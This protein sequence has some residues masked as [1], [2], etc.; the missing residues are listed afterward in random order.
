LS[1][2]KWKEGHNSY[3]QYE[4][5]QTVV[6][7][8]VNTDTY[9]LCHWMTIMMTG[10]AKCGLKL[11]DWTPVASIYLSVVHE[12]RHLEIGYNWTCVFVFNQF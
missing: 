11:D 2:S 5:H 7:L 12:C 10:F 3:I 1:N 4:T 8:H 6:D 9:S